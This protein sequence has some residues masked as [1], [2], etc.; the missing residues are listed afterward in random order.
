MRESYEGD[1]PSAGPTPEEESEEDPE[2]KKIVEEKGITQEDVDRLM[3]I[4]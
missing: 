3:S 1:D 2:V 4:L